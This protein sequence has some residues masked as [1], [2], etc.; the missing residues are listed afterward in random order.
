MTHQWSGLDLS[1]NDP[2]FFNRRTPSNLPPLSAPQTAMANFH[3][4]PR[5]SMAVD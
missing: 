5:A 4:P 1:L 2:G 3:E